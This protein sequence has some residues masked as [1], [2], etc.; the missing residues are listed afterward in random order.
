MA[1]RTLIVAAALALAATAAQAQP[2]P[3]VSNP[4]QLHGSTFSL[5]IEND[6]FTGPNNN[7]DRHY[8]SGLRANW[9]SP[10]VSGTPEWLRGFTDVSESALSFLDSRAAGPVRRRIGLSIGQ[11]IYTPQDKAAVDPSPSDRPYA[12]WLYA[13]FSLQTIRF[14]AS[15]IVPDAIRQDTWELDVGVVGPAAL[16][17][18]VQNSFH[19]FIGDEQSRGWSH[20][21]KNEPGVNLTFE[22]R[23][24]VGRLKLID[25]PLKLRFDAVPM[26]GFTVGNVNTYAAVGG[27]VR[28]GMN[29]GNDFGPPRIR[30]SLPGSDSIDPEGNFGWYVFAGAEGQGVLR[31]IT[32]DGN[33]FRNSPSVDKKPFVGDLTAGLAI[34][35]GGSRLAYTYVIRSKEFSGQKGIDQYGALTFTQR[36]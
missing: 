13:G 10:P 8:S 20:Q 16:G 26:I 11:S 24:R 1:W 4:F 9:L 35:V 3:E 17:R 29:L 7:K 36:F 27:I 19:V 12:A 2:A 6:F 33:T 14:D 30:P 5:Q 25:S 31:N 28:I 15:K 32:L 23:W 21:L 22:R 34:F 18:Q